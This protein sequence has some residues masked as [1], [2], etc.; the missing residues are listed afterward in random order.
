[1]EKLTL[2]SHINRSKEQFKDSFEVDHMSELDDFYDFLEAKINQA[3]TIGRMELGLSKEE[4]IDYFHGI[5]DLEEVE[6]K[7]T[8]MTKELVTRFLSKFSGLYAIK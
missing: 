8:G 4:R 7:T 1:M 5:L 6:D 3:W 2:K